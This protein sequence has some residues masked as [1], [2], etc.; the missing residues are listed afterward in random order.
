M[1]PIS[2][3]V[4]FCYESLGSK[5]FRIFLGI[6]FLNFRSSLPAFLAPSF[7]KKKNNIR[8]YRGSES[9]VLVSAQFCFSPSQKGSSRKSSIKMRAFGGF[10]MIE[11]RLSF[12][13]PQK[14]ATLTGMCFQSFPTFFFNHSFLLRLNFPSV[15]NYHGKVLGGNF[16]FAQYIA[17]FSSFP[18]LPNVPLWR[19]S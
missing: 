13:A 17:K 6:L 4:S 10:T 14:T 2:Q 19:D 15:T 5:Q 7:G 9:S 1:S 12:E 3:R 8:I 18:L 16:I 11:E